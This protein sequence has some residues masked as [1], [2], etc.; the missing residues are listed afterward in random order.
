MKHKI[1]LVVAISLLCACGSFKEGM[2]QSANVKAS[3]DK[4]FDANTFVGF[5]TMNGSLRTVNVTFDKLPSGKSLDDIIKEVKTSI[6]SEFK[7]SPQQIV[8]AF[9]V[10]P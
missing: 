8:I 10:K 9:S 3:L 1:L 7:E 2:Q 5:N 6:A 4:T